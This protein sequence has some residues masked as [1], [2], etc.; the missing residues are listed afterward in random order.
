MYNM[1]I[2]TRPDGI[3]NQH[4]TRRRRRRVQYGFSI[5]YRLVQ[6]IS[7]FCITLYNNLLILHEHRFK[8]VMN[9]IY[10]KYIRA[11]SAILFCTQIEVIAKK[12]IRSS[13]L[14]G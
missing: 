1:G 11:T 14:S 8:K 2:Y 7:I 6:Y 12:S 9:S 3:E 5:Q 4:W 10:F 13:S